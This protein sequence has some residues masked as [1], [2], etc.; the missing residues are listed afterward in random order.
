MFFWKGK[1]AWLDHFLCFKTTAGNRTNGAGFK[2]KQSERERKK[3]ERAREK[4]RGE[5]VCVRE[6]GEWTREENW[7]IFLAAANHFSCEVALEQTEKSVYVKESLHR[8]KSEKRRAKT[9]VD[10]SWAVFGV[11]K[12]ENK[13]TGSV[14]GD[15]LE[16]TVPEVQGSTWNEA[17]S[18]SLP[19]GYSP[20]TLNSL[21]GWTG[22][23]GST[24]PQPF[25]TQ[26]PFGPLYFPP[27]AERIATKKKHFHVWRTSFLL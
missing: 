14:S 6:R 12:E 24:Y 3:G 27:S 18:G 5:C 23:T 16:I 15:C 1:P 11:L 26:T 22:L 10:P 17:L 7:E 2:Q 21:P 25:W 9:C 20:L 19:S 8:K 13:R 4:K